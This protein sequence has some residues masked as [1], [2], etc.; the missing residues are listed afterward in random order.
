MLSGLSLFQVLF[1]MVATLGGQQW[2]TSCERRRDCPYAAG[3]PG[4]KGKHWAKDWERE[5][6][7]EVMRDVLPLKGLPVEDDPEAALK[8]LEGEWTYELSADGSVY[9]F[10]KVGSK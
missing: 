1:L 3:V 8:L 10:R 6:I 4:F 2:S 5:A 9:E 7:I